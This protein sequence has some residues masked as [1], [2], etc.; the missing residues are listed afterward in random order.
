MKLEPREEIEPVE[1]IDPLVRGAIF[2]E[3]QF[4]VLS[5]LRERAALP[6]TVDSLESALHVVS[7]ELGR[8][9]AK[10]REQLA[11][12]IDRVWDDGIA[13]ISAD[14]SEWLRRAAE[15]GDRWQP[16]RFELSFGLRDRE[17]ADPMSREDPVVIP[18]GLKLRGSIDLVER[19]PARGH[20]RITDHKT[21]KPR[22]TPNVVVGGGR[23]LQP[24]LYSLAAEALL[25][26]PVDCGRLY[27]CT[28]AGGFEEREVELNDAARQAAR[29]VLK[30]IVDSLEAGFFP[31]A[32]DVRECKWC[33]YRMLCG[34]YEPRRSSMKPIARLAALRKLRELV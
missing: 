9:T 7:Q 4:N 31:A 5:V 30:I 16:Y 2:H 12:A 33:D 6:V 23:V 24:L 13:N 11:P 10:Y 28:L 34:P 32:P 19:D 26:E 27:Y 8:V 17:Q 3:V 20:L 22:A 1:A 18:G 25:T 21:G 29:T 14:L 15:K